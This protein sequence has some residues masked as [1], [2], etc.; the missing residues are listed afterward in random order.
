MMISVDPGTTESAICI[1]H[2]MKNFEADKV[3]NINLLRW[4]KNHNRTDYP[5]AIE[6]IQGMGMAVGQEVF[7]TCR[8]VGR[9]EEAFGSPV[10]LVYRKEV[11]LHLCGS[12]KAKDAN[13]R[14]ALIDRFGSPG[15]KRAPG[16]TY[17]LSGDQWSAL[18]VGITALETKPKEISNG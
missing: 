2:S 15:T 3:S 14:Q 11:K 17:G 12:M 5:L 1:I 9:F 8:W 13:V 6:F 7:E 4:I 18:A 10:R 16:L